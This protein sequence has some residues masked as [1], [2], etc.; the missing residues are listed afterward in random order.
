VEVE[1]EAEGALGVGSALTTGPLPAL[2][3]AGQMAVHPLLAAGLTAGG[4]LMG[5]AGLAGLPLLLASGAPF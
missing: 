4:P 5:L 3:P 2:G 1:A